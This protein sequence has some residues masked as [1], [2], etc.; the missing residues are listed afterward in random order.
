[1][2]K[3]RLT[4]ELYILCSLDKGLSYGLHTKE[5]CSLKDRLKHMHI[6]VEDVA[7][8]LCEQESDETH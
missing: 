7:C 6:Q 8:G 2:P 4:L 3:G 1:M 5:H